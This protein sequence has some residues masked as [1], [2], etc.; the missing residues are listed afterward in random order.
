MYIHP[1]LWTKG[2]PFPPSLT[3][4]ARFILPLLPSPLL[5]QFLFLPFFS[6]LIHISCLWEG[7]LHTLC[8]PSGALQTLPPCSVMLDSSEFRVCSSYSKLQAVFPHAVFASCIAHITKCIQQQDCSHVNEWD[9]L[10]IECLSMKQSS[11]TALCVLVHYHF[12]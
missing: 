10:C 7:F 2:F 6:I 4:L 9:H 12:V 5:S 8:Y 11:S 1:K 3:F